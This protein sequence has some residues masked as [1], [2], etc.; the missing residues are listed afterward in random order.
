MEQEECLTAWYRKEMQ[1]EC[2]TAWYQKGMPGLMCRGPIFSDNCIRRD[3][4]GHYPYF[5]FGFSR[6]VLCDVYTWP[7]VYI[8]MLVV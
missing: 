8:I 1:E 6:I 4:S 2:L 7:K 3:L 5:M